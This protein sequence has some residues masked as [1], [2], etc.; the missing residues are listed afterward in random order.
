MTLVQ[1]LCGVLTGLAAAQAVAAEAHAGASL[2]GLADPTRPPYDAPAVEGDSAPAMGPELQ[3]VLISPT[4]KTA[5]ISGQ[6]VP[7]GGKFQDATLIRITESGVELRNGGQVQV[8]RMFP[9]VE[10]KLLP[11]DRPRR[12]N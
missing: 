1:L 4:R 7:L 11:T 6:T 8:L 5:V 12:R 9:R 2:Q 10:K 3:S